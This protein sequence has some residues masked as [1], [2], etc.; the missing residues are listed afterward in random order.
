[1][2]TVTSYQR[3]NWRRICDICGVWFNRSDLRRVGALI[4]CKD[5]KNERTKEQLSKAIARQRQDRVL[6]VPDAKPLNVTNPDILATDEGVIIDFLSRMTT[7]GARYEMV[8]SGASPF[9]RQADAVEAAGWVARYCYSLVAENTRPAS[10]VAQAKATLKTAADLLRS[11]QFG[12]GV[13]TSLTKTNSQFWGA[14]FVSGTNELVTEHT[15]MAGLAFLYAYRVFGTATYLASARACATYLRN[16]QAIG[17]HAAIRFTS[18][19]AAGT[20]RLYTGALASTVSLSG[21]FDC[22]HLFYPSGLLALEFWNELLTTDGD[23]QIGADTTVAGVFTTAPQQLMSQSM[24]DIRTCFQ[25]GIVD[26]TTTTIT[27]LSATTPREFFNAYPAVKNSFASITG[28]GLWEWSDSANGTFVTSQ[29]FCKALAALYA[30]DGASSQVTTVTDW[31]RSFTSN[32]TTEPPA[33]TSTQD[34]MHSSTG[35]YDP[36]VT[37]ATLLQVRDAAAS[38][39]PSAVNGSAVYDWGALGLL[40]PQLSARYQGSFKESRLV[41]LGLRRRFADGLP[42]D[43]LLDNISLK[44]RSGLSLQTGGME[45]VNGQSLIAND[46]L[47]CAQ[48]ALALRQAP[49]VRPVQA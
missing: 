36:T 25:T 12:F 6:P 44:G 31:L 42:S 46:A 41:P 48:F 38:F 7:A 13:S 30:V 20:A 17:S 4:I 10:V 26:A 45:T 5:E 43:W 33:G 22:D 47:T 29:T 1:M 3:G 14:V 32:S 16:V 39:A 18:S 8:T 34:L 28:T 11:R 21:T 2:G 24:T 15:I 35:T 27:G 49:K 40:S 23:Q 37:I 9:A 19:D